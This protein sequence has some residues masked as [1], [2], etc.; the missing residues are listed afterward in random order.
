MISGTG[1]ELFL[2]LLFFT[3]TLIA[4][5]LQKKGLKIKIRDIP[6]L[7]AIN[8][9]VRRCAEMNKPIIV[10]VGIGDQSKPETMAGLALVEHVSK[11]CAKLDI[12][13]I[14]TSTQSVIITALE[15]IIS[16]A[17][18]TAG[19]AELY[20]P[21]KYTRYFGNAQFAYV[22]GLSGIMQRERP[23]ACLYMGSIWDEMLM[24]PEVGNAVGAMQIGGSINV[25]TCG[26]LIATCDYA[27]FTEEIYA[28]AAELGDNQVLKASMLGQDVGKIFIMGMSILGF[29]LALFGNNIIYSL[30]E[31]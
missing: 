7:L 13:L 31:W 3:S 27:L 14:T 21:G 24:L 5:Y 6:A 23:G 8:E 16:E 9:A 30:L 15:G 29:I 20:T 4:Q 18:T 22:A 2:L 19:K 25:D 17:Y 11:Q 1:N 28:T 10:A 12:E 26:I